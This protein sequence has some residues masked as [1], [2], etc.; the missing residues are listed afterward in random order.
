M[1]IS[2]LSV[3]NQ[4]LM[5][6]DLISS[7]PMKE[8]LNQK[9]ETFSSSAPPLGLL[10]LATCAKQ[11]GHEVKVIDQPAQRLSSDQLI[12]RVMSHD[13]DIVGFSVLCDNLK[14]AKISAAGLKARNPNLRVVFGN[15]QATFFARRMLESYDWLDACVRGEGEVN[16]LEYLDAVEG[17]KDPEQVQGISYRADG[18]IHETENRPPIKNLDTIPIVDRSFLPSNYRNCVS[19]IDVS[20]RKFTILVSSR[21]CPYS[22]T[23]CA[24]RAFTGGTFRAR[25]TA[26]VIAELGQLREKK[27]RDV[28]FVDDN[29]T[30]NKKRVLDLCQE[31]RREKFDMDFTALG[32]INHSSLDMFREMKRASFCTIM[33][34]FESGVQRILDQYNKKITLDQSKHT[35]R[36]ARRAGI[37][38]ILG[39]FLIGAYDETYEEAMQTIKFISKLDIDFP[40]IVFTR[41]LPATQIYDT[42][43]QQGILDDQKYWETGVDVID[44]PGARMKRKA[45]SAILHSEYQ[46]LFYNFKYM[47]RATIR[48]FASRYRRELFINHINKPDLLQLASI[49]RD[50]REL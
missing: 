8:E 1:S 44:L 47:F 30:L 19:G 21:G 45:I 36:V 9:E 46:K 38:S 33:F 4:I 10:Y 35:V 22:C 32:R 48:G 50:P 31:I 37:D 6:I 49:L 18:R 13:P 3:A 29:F 42:L 28:I 40:Q 7:S 12:D 5:K 11:D 34:G 2:H 24:C 43:V 39:T 27:Y 16:F 26:N 25:S 17:N 41:A 20:K 23:F 14:S 15:Y